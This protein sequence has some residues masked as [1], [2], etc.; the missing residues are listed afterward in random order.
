VHLLVCLSAAVLPEC[1]FKPTS[2]HAGCCATHV[3]LSSSAAGATV[4]LPHA[5]Q[6]GY[7]P[8]DSALQCVP[9]VVRPLLLPEACQRTWYSSAL[10]SPGM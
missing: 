6:H 2:W 5:L 7:A 8:P 10:L 1:R 3:M 9:A 4:A